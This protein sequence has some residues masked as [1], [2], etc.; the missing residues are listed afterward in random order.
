MEDEVL[1][2]IQG[3]ILKTRL[4]NLF[5]VFNG[6]AMLEA[7]VAPTKD[8]APSQETTEVE[9]FDENRMTTVEDHIQPV[10]VKLEAK[11]M[12][13]HTVPEESVDVSTREPEP[14]EEVNLRDEKKAT[15]EDMIEVVSD[16]EAEESMDVQILAPIEE[17]ETEEILPAEEIEIV[18][19]SVS[20][21]KS[22]VVE[23][24]TP[25]YQEC[26]AS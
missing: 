16:K 11:L 26:R 19:Q 6:D 21:E 17:L 8:Q 20:T 1:A 7:A 18:Q 13:A 4:A 3:F 2:A 15:V 5:I 12:G 23:D 25:K 9:E 14:V 10:S 22:A 24:S